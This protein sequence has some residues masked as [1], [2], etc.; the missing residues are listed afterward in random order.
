MRFDH[1]KL[2]ADAGFVPGAVV[3]KRLLVGCDGGGIEFLQRVLAAK[4]EEKESETGL[5]GE[6]LIFQ[7]GGAEL[8]FKLRCAD[9]VADPAPEVGL[10]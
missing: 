2:V 9:G 10:P 1:E 8:C 6:A 3:V 5:L 4:F 7:V